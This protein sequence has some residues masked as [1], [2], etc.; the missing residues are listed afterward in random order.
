[1]MFDKLRGLVQNL[2]MSD[3]NT[4]DLNATLR[5]LIQTIDIANVLTEPVTASIRRLLETSA[6]ALG[7]DEASVLVREGEGGDLRFLTA[8]GSV[9]DQLVGMSVPS[10][11]GI[12]G[13][14][15]MSGQPMAV[16]DAEGDATFYAEVDQATGFTT[17]SI[18][19]VPL[20]FHDEIVGV[21]EYVNRTGS[22]PYA[23]F[24]PDEIDRAT[25]YADAV[26]AL[27]NSYEAAKLVRDLSTKTL[28]SSDEGDLASMRQWLSSLRRSNE[29]IE[30]MELAILLRELADRGDAERHLC[31]QLLETM[32]R[33]SDEKGEVS[34]LSY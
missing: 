11:K 26:A 27:V 25:V 6:A 24:T 16:S 7:T 31:K 17:Q 15:L 2:G 23:P 30:R 32:L 19:A 22:P 14:V 20:R 3:E 9:A 1:M 5:R 34:Y 4:N 29:H 13:F 12:A 10:G 33:Y 21:L 28:A 8:I 18:L